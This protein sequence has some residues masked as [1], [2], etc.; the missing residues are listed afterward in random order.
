MMP[1]RAEQGADLRETES[2]KG[3]VDHPRTSLDVLCSDFPAA[4]ISQRNPASS[5][6]PFE[7]PREI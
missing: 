7:S 6:S 5:Q 3:C 1:Y 4:S 2:G